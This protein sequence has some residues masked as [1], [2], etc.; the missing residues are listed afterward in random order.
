[1]DLSALDKNSFTTALGFILLDKT[2]FKARFTEK[3]KCTLKIY[4]I[5]YNGL[6]KAEGKSFTTA[7][8]MK[9]HFIAYNNL[10]LPLRTNI[11]NLNGH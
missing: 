8:Q 9:I 3:T 10:K 11:K 6:L 2:I 4:L 1:M 5:I 7:C